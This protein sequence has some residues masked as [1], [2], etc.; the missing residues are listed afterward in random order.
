MKENQEHWTDLQ[1][2]IALYQD[3]QGFV[4]RL[5]D[6]EPFMLDRDVAA[7]YGVENRRLMEQVN[8][9]RD[10]F[11]HEMLFQLTDAEAEAMVSQNAIPS[12][13][14]LGGHLPH[15]FTKLGANN[16]AFFLK[17]DTAKKRATQILK[18]FIY[19]EEASLYHGEPMDAADNFR[20]RVASGFREGFRLAGFCVA[21]GIDYD[22]LSTL[23]WFRQ[24]ALTQ[25]ETSA[26]LGISRDKVKV[27][28][29]ILRTVGLEFP[30][31][32]ATQRKKWMRDNLNESLKAVGG[33]PLPQ[34][35][36]LQPQTKEGGA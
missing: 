7:I 26:L 21:S 10:R 28:E 30:P 3:I 16:V 23:I 8:R 15:A 18:A 24:S 11:D 20:A 22:T 2:R 1:G 4:H 9:N 25:K 36:N 13:A 14:H 6:R 17:T 29:K 31:V 12:R 34:T 35:L 27:T 5:P 32:H 19:F 33:N